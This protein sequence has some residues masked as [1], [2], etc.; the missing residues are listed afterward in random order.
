MGQLS[1]MH[2]R[3][4]LFMLLVLT[5]APVAVAQRDFF[6][7]PPINYS[8]TTATDAMAR[9]A[10]AWAEGQAEKPA[11]EGRE[12]LRTLL[13]QLG[14]P[15]ESQV[16]VFSRTSKQN[17]LIRYQNP[18]A[19]YYSE[20]VYVGYVPGGHIEVSAADPVLGPVFYLLDMRKAGKPDFAGRDNSCL[21]CRGLTIKRFP[22]DRT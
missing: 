3:I 13:A 17:D 11:G 19:V 5:A 4:K 15:E 14:V 9:L 6:E 18:R 20:D 12:V 21:Q 1:G 2:S 8:E 22:V 10:R 16:L 7:L